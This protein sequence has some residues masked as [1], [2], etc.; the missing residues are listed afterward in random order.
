MSRFRFR[1][2]EP[3]STSTIIGVLAGAIGG[4]ALGMYVA[5]RVGGFE[6]L[7]ARFKARKGAGSGELAPSLDNE[8]EFDDIEE[9]DLEGD[10]VD[11][12]L[13]ERVL[14][15]FRNDPILAERAVDIGSIGDGII[16]L[17]GWVDTEMESEHAVTLARGVPD[18]DTVV[19]RLAIG[20]EESHFEE[21]ARRAASGDPAYAERHW[22]GN[23]IGTGR[24]RQGSSD[25][26]DR[27]EGPKVDLETRWSGT[28]DAIKDA[29]GDVGESGA[30]R[31]TGKGSAKGDRSGGVPKADHVT[32]Q[33]D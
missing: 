16:E 10:A 25:E 31:R 5:Q 28:A 26:P 30:R 8:D 4:F 15:A 7:T 17:A 9:D 11:Q 6:G 14:E 27:H 23:T 1:D 21:N 12:G 13:E 3:S 24:R 22:E 19:N 2:D 32:G 18:V 20:S 29:A 33:A